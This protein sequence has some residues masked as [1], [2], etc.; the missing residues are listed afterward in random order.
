MNMYI[1]IS[2]GKGVW[3]VMCGQRVACVLPSK[4]EAEKLACVL[5]HKSPGIE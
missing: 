5:N 2:C 4:N 3:A 1:V